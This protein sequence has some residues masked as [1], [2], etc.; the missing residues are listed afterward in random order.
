MS[1]NTSRRTIYNMQNILLL[2]HVN[3]TKATPI[4]S[5]SVYYVWGT[6]SSGSDSPLLSHLLLQ[7]LHTGPRALQTHPLWLYTPQ[8]GEHT[9]HS[10]AH[11]D[12]LTHTHTALCHFM[13]FYIRFLSSMSHLSS[14]PRVFLLCTTSGPRSTSTCWPVFV[15]RIFHWYGEVY[16]CHCESGSIKFSSFTQTCVCIMNSQTLFMSRALYSISIAEVQHCSVIAKLA[17]TAFMVNSAYIPHMSAQ[18]E[19]NFAFQL[20]YLI[21]IE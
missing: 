21:Q 8:G 2:V 5:R 18:W 19:I 10:N 7:T 17:K 13:E 3:I 12:A 15:R 14:M 11:T 9:S 1:R 4:I 6:V 20:R 16:L